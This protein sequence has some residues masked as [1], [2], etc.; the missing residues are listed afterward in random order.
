MFP[1]GAY[2][3]QYDEIEYMFQRWWGFVHRF[4]NYKFEIFISE[5]GLSDN[6]HLI[7]TILKAKFEKLG[8]KKFIYHNFKQYDSEQFKLD[9][10]NSM[11]A[12][13]T[14]AAFENTFVTILDKHAPKKTEI[15]RGNQTP[16]F[17]KKLR[18]QIMIR[19]RL[20]NK[21]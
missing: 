1:S 11:S 14:H 21:G 5:T 3:L 17:N 15:L 2:I 6:H 13:R 18:K 7:Y 10:C 9:I 4:T 16:Y 19:S 8:P 20:Q 12:V